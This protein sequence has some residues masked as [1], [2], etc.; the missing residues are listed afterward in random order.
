MAASL[1][2]AQDILSGAI[3]AGFR[4]SGVQSLGNLDEPNS[5]PMVAVRTSGLA[6]SS[7]IGYMRNSENDEEIQGM[8]NEEYLEVLL[9]IANQR[10]DQNAE[11]IQRFSDNLFQKENKVGSAWE[12]KRVRQERKRTEGLKQQQRLREEKKGKKDLQHKDDCMGLIGD[13]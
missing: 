8:V 9:S 5:F 13:E 1:H 11:R 7:L 12:D 2:H 10:F 3:S 6:L 4:E